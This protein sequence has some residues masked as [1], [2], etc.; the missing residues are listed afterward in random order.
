MGYLNR[1]NRL[2]ELQ[3]PEAVGEVDVKKRFHIT[4]RIHKYMQASSISNWFKVYLEIRRFFH[5]WVRNA[6][7]QRNTIVF[8]IIYGLI[9]GSLSY[10]Y[11]SP[12]SCIQT[13]P[14]VITCTGDHSAGIASSQDFPSSPAFDTLNV[15]FLSTDIKPSTGVKGISLV[16]LT[17]GDLTVVYEGFQNTIQTQGDGAHGLAVDS[18]GGEDGYR[19]RFQ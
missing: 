1:W 3:P 12:G 8:F 15:N 13:G 19:F 14:Q 7:F 11:A 2:L 17:G 10:A 6:V 9:I 5:A 18:Q 16:S 4:V